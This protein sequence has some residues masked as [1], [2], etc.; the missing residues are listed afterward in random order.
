MKATSQRFA[1]TAS[2]L[3]GVLLVV[4]GVLA[5]SFP[6][7]ALKLVVIAG[8]SLLLVDGLLGSL[9]SRHYGIE[10]SWP[11]WLSL[12]RGFLAMLAGLALLF[13]PF[14][15]TVLTP[16]VLARG[17][18]AA[19]LAV[20]LVELVVLLGFRKAVPA[21]WNTV[22]G[23]II[24]AGVGLT[25]LFLPLSGALLMLQVGAGLLALFGVLQVAKAWSLA[26]GN[27][28]ARRPG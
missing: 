21:A 18:G 11:F 24:Y 1:L 14:L 4:A 3:R 22:L 2:L 19:A 6:V 27:L 26:S 10:A 12:S 9:A 23:A 7:L 13:S 5:L 15:A 17:I 20:G 16:E 28:G 25:L 8:G